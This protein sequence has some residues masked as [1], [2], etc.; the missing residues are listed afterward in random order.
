MGD[1]GRVG[2]DGSCGTTASAEDLGDRLNVS[3]VRSFA[4][5]A[6]PQYLFC[7][8]S[9]SSNASKKGAGQNPRLGGETTDLPDASQTSAT[10]HLSKDRHPKKNRWWCRHPPTKKQTNKS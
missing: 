2:R 3:P 7:G 9:A 10:S 6:F 4:N 8:K 5:F 1:D